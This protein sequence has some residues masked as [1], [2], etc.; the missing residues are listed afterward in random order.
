MYAVRHK[1]NK[2]HQP[3]CI[4]IITIPHLKKVKYGQTHIMKP[5]VDWFEERGVR[6]YSHTI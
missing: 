4:G 3:L 2:R 5:Y 1:T 6:C